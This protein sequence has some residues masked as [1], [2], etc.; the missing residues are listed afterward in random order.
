M[1]YLGCI[2]DESLSGESMVLYVLSKLNSKLKFL[3]RKNRFLTPLLRKLLCNALIQPHFDFACNAWF[4]SLNQNLKNKL[5]TS[6]NKCIRFC[7][8]LGNRTHIGVDEFKKINV[9][10]RFNQCVSSNVY[11]FFQK[12]SPPYMAF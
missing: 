12:K 11:N 6:Q 1:K 8:Q 10:E 2:L 4:P 9:E 5:Q 3:Y 7:L